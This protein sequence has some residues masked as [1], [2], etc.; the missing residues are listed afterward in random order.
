MPDDLWLV[1]QRVQK[2][3][4]LAHGLVGE[5]LLATHFSE[6]GGRDA[7]EQAVGGVHTALVIRRARRKRP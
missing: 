3:P 2:D 1:G 5:C 4:S 6:T 7:R